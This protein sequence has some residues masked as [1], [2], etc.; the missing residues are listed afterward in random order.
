LASIDLL[1]VGIISL[2]TLGQ[3]ANKDEVATF[4][5][6]LYVEQMKFNYR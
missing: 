1:N 5:V 2:E 6:E 4:T 3:E